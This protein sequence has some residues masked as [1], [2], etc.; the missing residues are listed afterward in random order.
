VKNRTDCTK[1]LSLLLKPSEP[2]SKLRIKHS[3]IEEYFRYKDCMFPKSLVE[4][5]INKNTTY[6]VAAKNEIY[7]IMFFL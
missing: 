4:A 5:S 3:T 7:L 2:I 6:I 1:N